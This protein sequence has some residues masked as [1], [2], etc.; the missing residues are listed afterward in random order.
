LRGNDIVKLDTASPIFSS[1]DP[2]KIALLFDVDGTLIDIGPSP[3]EVDVPDELKEA[4]ARLCDLTSG[5]LALVSGRPIRDLDTLF[6]PLR[7]PAVGGHGAETRLAEGARVSR[8]GDLPQ[9][10][11]RHLV[12]AAVPG[13][14]IEVEDKG[15]SVALHYRK[16]PKEAEALRRHIAAGRAA[17]PNE[18]TELLLG[19]AMF[20]V[21]RPGVNKGDAVR[22][23]MTEGQFA[24]RI[25]VFLGDDITD[26]SVFEILPALGGKGFGVGRHFPQ[27]AGIFP[28]PS[29]VRRALRQLAA[30]TRPA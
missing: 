3:F 20:E 25:P 15:Y 14:G 11:R 18:K 26:E 5:A 8:I 24:G 23:L 19:K 9:A 22:A 13:S 2:A 7:L 6:E 10:L 30:S 1:L 12:E 29:D 16:A 4:L 17:F 27:V 28:A 21:K